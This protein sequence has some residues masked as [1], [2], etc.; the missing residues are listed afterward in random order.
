MNCQRFENVVSELARGQM[1]AAEQRG[2]ALAHSET[3]EQ[4]A[5]RL[6]DEEMLT[7]GL[8]S[9]AA[10]MEPLGAPA[11]V[12]SKLLE[13][14]RN[15]HV[16]TPITVTRRS[17]ARY[18][19]AAIAAML[20]IAISVVVFRWTNGVEEPREVVKQEK[21][22]V[23]PENRVPENRPAEQFTAV[24]Q[25]RDEPLPQRP[26]PKRNR[27][28]GVRPELANH[29]NNEIA[30]DFIPLSYMSA[31]SLQDGGQIVRVQLPRAALANFGLPVNMDRYNERVKADVLFGVDGRAHAIRFV[32]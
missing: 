20:L 7:R 27:S 5:A 17:N 6:R 32:Q 16:V 4:C 29:V 24:D 3:C 13:A 12:E 22:Q 21:P 8:Q 11:A 25:K 14:F 15:R 26:K 1:M 30:T 28:T 10:E 19:A 31:A 2:E 23:T 18:W 9:L